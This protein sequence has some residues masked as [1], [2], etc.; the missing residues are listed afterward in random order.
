MLA[1]TRKNGEGFTIG[2]DIRVIVLRSGDGSTRVGIE[3]PRDLDIA[4]FV[5]TPPKPVIDE[6]AKS[7]AKHAAAADRRRSRLQQKHNPPEVL[8]LFAADPHC[9]R[10]GCE[11]RLKTGNLKID[12]KPNTAHAVDGSLVCCK[13]VPIEVPRRPRQWSIERPPAFS[14]FNDEVK[15]A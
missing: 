4:R 3:A 15:A 1:L 13:C 2:P 5:E 10:C 11:L 6:V 7:I 8:A 12:A 9:S 14:L